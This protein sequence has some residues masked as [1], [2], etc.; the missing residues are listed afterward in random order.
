MRTLCSSVKFWTPHVKSKS[1]LNSAMGHKSWQGSDQICSHR[2][3]CSRTNL[4]S[5]TCASRVASVVEWCKAGI[6]HPSS[7]L[8]FGK[9]LVL[10]HCMGSGKTGCSVSTSLLTSEKC[11]GMICLA[12]E[13]RVKLQRHW[14]GDVGNWALKAHLHWVNLEMILWIL[15]CFQ[16]KQQ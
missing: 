4:T 6:V 9:L 1:S 16:Q 11:N 13:T 8:C 3:F 7:E 10:H 15:A 12:Q 14:A 5:S 2:I